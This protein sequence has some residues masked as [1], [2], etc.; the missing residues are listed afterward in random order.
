MCM[1]AEDWEVVEANAWRVEATLLQQTSVVYT[2]QVLPFWV[3]EVRKLVTCH[4]HTHTQPKGLSS[5]C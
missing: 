2:G 1:F 4:T 3:N 5:S